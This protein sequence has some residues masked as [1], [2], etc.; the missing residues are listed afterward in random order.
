MST[1]IAYSAAERASFVLVPET[2]PAVEG[3]IDAAFDVN[4]F[5]MAEINAVL[6]KYGIE[7]DK[8][9]Q[10]ALAELVGVRLFAKKRALT[11]VVLHE[12]TFP[13]RAALVAQVQKTHGL[14]VERNHFAEWVEHYQGDRT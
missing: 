3:A 14:P 8:R 7:A 9:L 11:K 5:T 4:A 2:C 10:F 13:L 1:R 12:G 6:S